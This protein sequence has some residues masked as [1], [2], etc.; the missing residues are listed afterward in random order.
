MISI[1][2][3]I[4]N[5]NII[6]KD[7][8]LPFNLPI[9]LK[10]FKLH[11]INKPIIMGRKT[12]QSIKKKPLVKRYN[13]IITRKYNYYKYNKQIIFT[14]SIKKAIKIAKKKSLEIMIIGGESLYKQTIKLA[15]RMYL[16][17]YNKNIYGNKYFP[18]FNKKKWKIIFRKKIFL[19]KKEF[20][21]FKILDK[22][23]YVI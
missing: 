10:W 17:L 1:I 13:I 15:N 2:S 3:I 19:K 21:I 9:D 22:N 4:S 23:N 5:N 14:N 6:G 20:I 7:N 8:F 18:K 16:T 11:T 12:W